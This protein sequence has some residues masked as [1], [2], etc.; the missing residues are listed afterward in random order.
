M[1]S[2]EVIKM[3]EVKTKYGIFHVEETEV[4]YQVLVYFSRYDEKII[5]IFQEFFVASGT[6]RAVMEEG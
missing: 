3:V 2:R 5:K 4:D 1:L 6:A